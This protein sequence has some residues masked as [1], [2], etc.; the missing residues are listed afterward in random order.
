MQAFIG[1]QLV[2]LTIW[3]RCQ[4]NKRILMSRTKVGTTRQHKKMLMLS[5]VFVYFIVS[6]IL[7]SV[8]Q[9]NKFSRVSRIVLEKKRQGF[10]FGII[11][12]ISVWFLVWFYMYFKAFKTLWIPASIFIVIFTQLRVLYTTHIQQI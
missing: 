11:F 7:S 12:G 4:D 9:H 5:L 3:V 8:T 1:R 10:E 6:N 2:R